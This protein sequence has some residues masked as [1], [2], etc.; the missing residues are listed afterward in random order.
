MLQGPQ[1]PTESRRAPKIG[2]WPAGKN[3]L[4]NRDIVCNVLDE[5]MSPRIDIIALPAL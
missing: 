2:H 1:I 5:M 3:L 4:P